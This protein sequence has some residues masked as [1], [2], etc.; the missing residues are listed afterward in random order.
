MSSREYYLEQARALL[1]LAAKMSAK[2]D[3]AQLIARANEY[4]MLAETTPDEPSAPPPTLPKPTTQSMQ[5]QQAKT[6]DKD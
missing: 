4:Q 3:A 6:E 1:E 5:Q 2:D